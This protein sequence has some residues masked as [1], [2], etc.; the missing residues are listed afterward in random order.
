MNEPQTLS[1]LNILKR[2]YFQLVEPSHLR[3]PN[4]AILKLPQVQSWLYQNLFDADRIA[5]PPL[6]LYQFRVLKVLI[7]RLEKL[8]EDPDEDV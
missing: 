1:Q 5:S 6:E 3:W 7:S 4:E 8:I 2:Q